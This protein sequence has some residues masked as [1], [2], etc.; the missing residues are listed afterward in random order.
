MTRSWSSEESV[1][2][3]RSWWTRTNDWYLHHVNCCRNER[4]AENG[5]QPRF[6]WTGVI[7]RFYRNIRAALY[8]LRTVACCLSIREHCDCFLKFA[9][10]VNCFLFLLFLL[11]RRQVGSSRRSCGAGK[12]T[13]A[14]SQHWDDR[15]RFRRRQISACSEFGARAPEW[16]PG[17]TRGYAAFAS[18]VTC[19][20]GYQCDS[21]ERQFSFK[22]RVRTCSKRWAPRS[23]HRICC[24]FT[25]RLLTT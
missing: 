14:Q 18:H 10:H 16:R 3:C 12:R 21:V 23:V 4:K 2:A 7:H 19:V 17:K 24:F 15:F 1:G 8:T 20:A 22:T 5:Q 9:L 6:Q 13:G 25:I 11:Y